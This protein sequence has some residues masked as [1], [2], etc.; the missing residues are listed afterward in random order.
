ML[1][2]WKF[3]LYILRTYAHVHMHGHTH[4]SVSKPK[5]VSLAWGNAKT[6]GETG[7]EVLRRVISTAWAFN[8]GS[9]TLSKSSGKQTLS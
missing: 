1:L 6:E 2:K 9:A 5:N 4:T 3:F 8:P 7:C